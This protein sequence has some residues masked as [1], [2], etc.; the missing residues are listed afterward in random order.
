MF[1]EAKH[2]ILGKRQK[3]IETY[4]ISPAMLDLQQKISNA[5]AKMTEEKSHLSFFLA[6]N[7]EKLLNSQYKQ[8]I[9]FKIEAW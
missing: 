5:V 6:D 3:R 9:D 4:P 8:D 2:R 7:L 1:S